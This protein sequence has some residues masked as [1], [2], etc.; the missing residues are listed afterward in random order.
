MNGL[1][2]V[3]FVLFIILLLCLAF[4]KQGRHRPHLEFTVTCTFFPPLSR[5]EGRKKTTT[6]RSQ[7]FVKYQNSWVIHHQR[8]LINK[9]GFRAQSFQNMDSIYICCHSNLTDLKKGEEFYPIFC[10]KLHWILEY[11]PFQFQSLILKS[12]SLYSPKCDL[13]IVVSHCDSCLSLEMRRCCIT[14]TRTQASIYLQK[15]HNPLQYI[16][17][18]NFCF[19]VWPPCA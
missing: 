1:K 3:S 18:C 10:S 4:C 13:S 6:K 12:K 17:S 9:S 7:L 5:G 2:R 15:F 8:W 14:S 19:Q 11:L 16:L